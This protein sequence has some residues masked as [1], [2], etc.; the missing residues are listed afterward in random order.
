MSN[1]LLTPQMAMAERARRELARR[2]LAHFGQYMEPKWTIAPHQRLICQYLEKVYRYIETHGQEGIG[3]L[4]IEMP[5]QHT[6]TTWASRFFPAWLLGK[7][8]DSNVLLTAYGADL[9]TENSRKVRN[10]I[11]GERY[12]NIF[13]ERSALAEAV[14]I[15]SDSRSTTSWNLSDPY[16]GGVV[17]AGVGGG[18]TGRPADLLVIDDPVKNRQ[19]ADSIQHRKSVLSWFDSSAMTRVRKGT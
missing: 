16:T 1:K 4:I 14:E 5:P 3:R 10:M 15:S 7:R 11:Q 12:K 6:K 9:A 18:I 13:G 19:E 8:P 17:A 2:H